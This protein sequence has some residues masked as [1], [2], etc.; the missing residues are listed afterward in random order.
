MQRI[1]IIGR[2]GS[3]KSTLAR[4]LGRRLG[5]PVTHLDAL[6][7]QPGWQPPADRAAFDARVL[8]VVATDRWIIDGGYST[9]LPERLRRADTLI[10][11][12]APLWL[13]FSRVL[14]R[15]VAYR[16]KTRPD[17]GLDC[18]EKVDLEFLSYIWSYRRKT[19]PRNERLFAEHF[20]GKPIRL[21]SRRDVEAFLETVG[22]AA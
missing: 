11:M 4:E 21:S 20:A 16:G 15:V 14:W 19:L 2:S 3:G 18:P 6:Y 10:V 13:C 17:M 5:L 1:V 8:D 12:M 22:S 9:T 7:W